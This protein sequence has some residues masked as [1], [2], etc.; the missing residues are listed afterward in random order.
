MLWTHLTRELLYLRFLQARHAILAIRNNF[1][2]L[3]G[4]LV[5]RCGIARCL[6]VFKTT[7]LGNRVL[8]AANGQSDLLIDHSGH[9]GR[10]RNRLRDENASFSLAPKC[11]DSR[12]FANPMW[13]FKRW[14]GV[15]SQMGRTKRLLNLSQLYGSKV[16]CPS[17][18]I[19][20]V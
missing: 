5:H 19:P 3:C 10:G 4:R 17:L 16:S 12:P 1:L 14:P 6:E 13:A 11:K 2:V 9:I 8:S 7:K 20:A 18:T 15:A